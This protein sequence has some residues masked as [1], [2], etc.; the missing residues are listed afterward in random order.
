[1]NIMSVL[2]SRHSS[3]SF[4]N[5]LVHLDVTI[6]RG[7][8]VRTMEVEQAHV[9]PDIEHFDD[10]GGAIIVGVRKANALQIDALCVISQR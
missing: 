9:V 10:F 5:I 8:R 1:M 7:E 2:H 3:P 6:S 4:W